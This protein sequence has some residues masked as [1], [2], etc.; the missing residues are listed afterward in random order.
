MEVTTSLHSLELAR[1]ERGPMSSR[2]LYYFIA[3]SGD[4]T[5]LEQT[6]IPAIRSNTAE[7]LNP[8]IRNLGYRGIGKNHW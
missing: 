6:V 5:P 1:S 4:V 7:Y 3:R 2:N 8:P